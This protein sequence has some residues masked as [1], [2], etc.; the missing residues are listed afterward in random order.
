MLFYIHFMSQISSILVCKAI[1]RPKCMENHTCV[2]TCGL[3]RVVY[4]GSSNC[5]IYLLKEIEIQASMYAYPSPIALVV[6]NLFKPP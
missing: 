2:M 5:F 1:Y 4:I 6:S 3:L